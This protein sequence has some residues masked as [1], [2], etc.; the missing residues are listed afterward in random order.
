M[1]IYINYF[2]GMLVDQD[3]GEADFATALAGL[4]AVAA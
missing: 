2:G 1:Q 4:L 3:Y